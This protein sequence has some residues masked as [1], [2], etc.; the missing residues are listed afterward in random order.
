MLIE[1]KPG[2]FHASELHPQSG[3]VRKVEAR[4][5]DLC[6]IRPSSYGLQEKTM[7]KQVHRQSARTQQETARL[8][9]DRERYQRDKPTPEQLLAEGAHQ[10][11]VSLLVASSNIP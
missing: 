1:R 3:R 11:F 7:M 4:A 2:F 8:K 10:E 9:A 6:M 5:P